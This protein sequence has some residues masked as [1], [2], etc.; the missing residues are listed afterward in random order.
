[1]N[2]KETEALIEFIELEISMARNFKFDMS[3]YLQVSILNPS[4]Q[5]NSSCCLAGSN[6][7]RLIGYNQTFKDIYNWRS[8]YDY[9]TH[10]SFILSMNNLGLNNSQARI[11]FRTYAKE[12]E[13]KRYGDPWEGISEDPQTETDPR[14]GIQA[15]KR[16]LELWGDPIE[17]IETKEVIYEEVNK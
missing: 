16:A 11:L 7:I 3:D 9:S 14:K 1:M 8:R 12:E 10:P 2:R 17:E 5:C 15:L 13:L 4:V 6:S